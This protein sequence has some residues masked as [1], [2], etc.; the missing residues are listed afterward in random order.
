MGK[1]ELSGISEILGLRPAEFREKH[2][3]LSRGRRRLNGEYDKPCIF[4]REGEGC[5]IYEARPRQCRSFPFWLEHMKDPENFAE[6]AGFCRG[7]KELVRIKEKEG[8]DE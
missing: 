1:D 7:V 8:R 3:E 4:F 5:L 2:L 6:I